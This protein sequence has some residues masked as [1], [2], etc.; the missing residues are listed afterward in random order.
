MNALRDTLN[1]RQAREEIEIALRRA[2]DQCIR[3]WHI[4][5]EQEYNGSLTPELIMRVLFGTQEV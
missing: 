5:R 4:G 1:S 3:W 2:Q